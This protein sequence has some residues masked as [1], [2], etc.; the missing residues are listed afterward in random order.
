MSSQKRKP[1]FGTG[2]ALDTGK[3]TGRPSG[4]LARLSAGM[5]VLFKEFH[6]G[7]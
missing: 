2:N 1:G 5:S 7:C 3:Q 4:R 6:D